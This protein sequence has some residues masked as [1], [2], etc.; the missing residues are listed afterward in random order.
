MKAAI[1]APDPLASYASRTPVRA[2][3]AACAS[4]ST[5]IRGGSCATRHVTSLGYAATSASAVTAPPLLANISTGPTPRAHD[6]VHIVCLDGGSVDYLAIF[7]DAAAEAARVIGDHG[8]IGEVRRQRTEAAGVH[9]LGDHE[10]WWASSSGG[11]RA[12]DVVDDVGL[13]GFKLV[14]RHMSIDFSLVE[15]SSDSTPRRGVVKVGPAAD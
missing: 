14:C 1:P 3:S 12:V 4:G 11:Q 13:D 15:N 9:G 6:G 5:G 8:A 7:A 10:Q 2:R